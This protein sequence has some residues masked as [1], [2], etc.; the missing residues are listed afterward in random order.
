M[1]GRPETLTED[2]DR[3]S[4]KGFDDF[5]LLLGDIM[6]GE[7][8][9][10]GKSLLDVQRELKIKATYI[11]AIENT[12]PSAFDTPGFIAGYVRSY[13]RYLGLDPEWAFKTFCDE[14][15]FAVAHGMSAD[16]S[17]RRVS[18]PSK[19][20]QRT[21]GAKVPGASSKP[22]HLRDP[23]TEPSVELDAWVPDGRG[24][25]RWTELLGSGMVHPNVLRH[26]GHDPD[27][28]QGFAF[29]IGIER[30]AMVR[31]GVPDLRLF[32]DNDVRL[33]ASF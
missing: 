1:I 16:A 28:V 7:R 25:G 6:R 33:L 14:G 2:E 24:G 13:A 9:T 31:Y 15:N 22:A 3:R 4:P 30:T 21:P 19:Q 12:D 32:A 18:Q 10:M 17:V 20:A 23:F 11:A 29:G 5:D 8:A 27:E 26:G